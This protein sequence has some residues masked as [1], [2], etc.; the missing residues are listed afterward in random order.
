MKK[1]KKIVVIL[2][3]SLLIVFFYDQYKYEQFNH[4]HK[5]PVFA[6]HR[7]VPDDI[8]NKHKNN[9]WIG[10]IK[11][12]EDM[13][14]YLYN[15]GYKTLNIKEFFKWYIGEVE[16]NKK[17]VLIT[18]DDGHYEDY[19]LV[20]PIIKKYKFKA[21]S[22][23]V[24]SRIKNKTNPYN[25]FVDSYVGMDVINKIR[26][27]YPYFEFQSHSFN[28]H[29][30]IRNNKG[31]FINRIYNM[32]L[33]ELESDIIKNEKYGFTSMAYPYGSSNEEIKKLLRKYGYLIS[34]RFGPSEFATRNSKRFAIPR[35]KLNDK[36]TLD[37]LKNWLK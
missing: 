35:I 37:T 18:I 15:N 5:M 36:A 2:E 22:F 29:Y 7:L 33:K 32:S 12:F 30:H 9:E 8:K 10:R 3:L 13:I 21:T 6:F 27:E 11:I 14:K 23:I 4:T 24:G 26:K 34:F 20:Y 19:Y 1:K 25:K 28:M 16:L 17:T 31:K